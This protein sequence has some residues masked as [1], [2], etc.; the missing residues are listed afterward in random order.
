MRPCRCVESWWW[1]PRTPALLL[2]AARDLSH[3]R[4]Q[5]LG[6]TTRR[7]CQNRCVCRQHEL[8]QLHDLRLLGVRDR[9]VAGAAG[10]LGRRRSIAPALTLGT[11]G[12]TARSGIDPGRRS[13]PQVV[14]H[15]MLPTVAAVDDRRRGAAVYGRDP[16]P[17]LVAALVA[18]APPRLV[19]EAGEGGAAR[20]A[21]DREREA[22]PAGA[23][24]DPRRR[25]GGA[26]RR[27]RGAGR[28]TRSPRCAALRTQ[29]RR[30]R[31]LGRA[32]EDPVDPGDDRRA[33]SELP[34]RVRVHAEGSITEMGR[35]SR[36]IRVLREAA[37]VDRIAAGRGQRACER[38]Q[39]DRG[40][41]ALADCDERGTGW[42][43]RVRVSSSGCGLV[44]ERRVDVEKRVRPR[45]SG[46]S[47]SA[48]W[49]E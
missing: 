31:H 34:L 37:P 3:H 39:A 15:G 6:T 35:W 14:G 28:H 30:D 24:R 18:A 33:F 2:D 48:T 5:R 36:S 9:D 29:P 45:L 43:D 8:V 23:D 11:T 20:A 12:R 17:E 25:G 1:E 26:R 38:A 47:T 44:G 13:A 19:P 46:E 10:A 21:A 40:G 41:E 22:P 27:H 16:D 32:H 4:E 7:I 42:D 49:T